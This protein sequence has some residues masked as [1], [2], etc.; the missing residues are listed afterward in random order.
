[1]SSLYITLKIL[2][3]AAVSAYLGY[4]HGINKSKQ[5]LFPFYLLQM[6][7]AGIAKIDYNKM[8]NEIKDSIPG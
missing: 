4:Q 5:K 8:I 7:K 3:L 2:T 6:E 1:M